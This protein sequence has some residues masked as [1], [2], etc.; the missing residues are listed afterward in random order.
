MK[1]SDLKTIG[2]KLSKSSNSIYEKSYPDGTILRVDLA[3]EHISYGKIR[4][5]R[6]TITNFSKEEN[7]VVLECVDRLL[8]LGYLGKNLYLENIT[9]ALIFERL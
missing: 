9:G 7:F 3:K 4:I 5:D 2:F 6:N 1:D 8:C